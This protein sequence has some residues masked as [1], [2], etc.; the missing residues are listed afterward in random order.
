MAG[1]KRRVSYIHL[2]ENMRKG[3]NIGFVKTD[4]QGGKCRIEVRMNGV[5][6]NG[7]EI[8]EIYSLVKKKD[9]AT[10]YFV[11]D[12]SLERQCGECSFQKEE[13]RIDD[14]GSKIED[15][16][17]FAFQLSEN[18][19]ALSLLDG[20]GPAFHEVWI[21]DREYSPDGVV[22]HSEEAV[23]FMPQDE[24]V[25]TE[26]IIYTN[27]SDQSEP[28]GQTEEEPE[29]EYPEIET[30]D[31]SAQAPD[32]E[33]QSENI[34]DDSENRKK[35]SKDVSVI[36]PFEDVTGYVFYKISPDNLMNLAAEY[37]IM[38]HNS[39]LLHGYYNYQYLIIGQKDGDRWILGVPG[40]YHDREQMMASMFGFPEFKSAK[41]GKVVLGTFGYYLKEVRVNGDLWNISPRPV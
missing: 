31:S 5:Y 33:S 40:V 29:S 22:M 10:G 41:K 36:T 21:R 32:T 28:D 2:Y 26:D 35:D 16:E 39:F 37:E 3:R 19:L 30:A 20:T 27:Q 38:Q 1:F 25:P 11:G 8:C 14:N 34:Q 18:R 17:G 12:F 23:E 9:A 24:S 15:I 7:K 4:V 6:T 13:S